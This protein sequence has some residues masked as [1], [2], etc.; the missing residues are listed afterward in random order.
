MNKVLKRHQQL[1]N[2]VDARVQRIQDKMDNMH[3]DAERRMAEAESKMRDWREEKYREFNW[4]KKRAVLPHRCHSTNAI[5]WPGQEYW[6]GRLKDPQNP[7][8]DWGLRIQRFM[9]VPGM[10]FEKIKDPAIGT[11]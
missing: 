10:T 9:S 5:I 2:R 11:N 6:H 7:D 1:R 3:K 4:Y 8:R